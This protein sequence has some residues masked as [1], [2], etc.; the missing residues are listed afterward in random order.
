[1]AQRRENYFEKR[2]D[3]K[4][5]EIW[6]RLDREGT[7]R[8]VSRP[9]RFRKGDKLLDLTA[10]EPTKLRHGGRGVG[11]KSV[12]LSKKALRYWVENRIPKGARKLPAIERARKAQR[13]LIEQG[14]NPDDIRV[15][16]RRGDGSMRRFTV[17]SWAR[18][19]AQEKYR[20]ARDR[21]EGT[22]TDFVLGVADELGDLGREVEQLVDFMEGE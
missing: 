5:R 8:R 14:T 12:P 7:P 2:H 18:F 6:Y 15:W 11:F 13:R 10:D 22:E 17:S 19:M 3:A 1:M 20:E 4:G 16:Q 9:E 21:L